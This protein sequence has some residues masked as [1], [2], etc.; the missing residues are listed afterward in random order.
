MV[1]I[2]NGKG[3]SGKDA[4]IQTL[5]KTVEIDDGEHV[6]YNLSTITPIKRLA[7]VGGWDD[8]KSE[9]G[10]KLLSDLKRLFTEYNDYPLTTILN[11]VAWC[12]ENV[13]TEPIFF[14]HCREPNEIAKVTRAFRDKSF[15]VATLLVKRPS[16]QGTV[17]GNASDDNVEYYPYDV[18]FV[19][20][21]EGADG[22]PQETAEKFAAVVRDLYRSAT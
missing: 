3:A 2:I 6:V 20:D 19:N 16:L 17:Y 8:D 10:R 14:V 11:D 9:K 7:R 5:G 1:I 21:K 22:I 18:I 15:R 12:S 13:E 4:L